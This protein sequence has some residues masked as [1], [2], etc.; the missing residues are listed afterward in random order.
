M[1]TRK[2]PTE[3]ITKSREYDLEHIGYDS[4]FL[5]RVVLVDIYKPKKHFPADD[6]SLLL[7]NDGQD[8]PEMPFLQI[9]S[10]L[11]KSNQV[12]PL[13]VAAMHCNADRRLEY[14]TA[15]VL[16]YMNRGARAKYHRKFVIRELIPFLQSKIAPFSFSNIGFAGFSLGGLS[17]LD[18]AWKNQDIFS[19][20]GV[21][22]GSFWWRKRALNDGYVEETDRIMHSLIEAGQYEGKQQYFFQTGQLDEKMDRNHNGI[23]DSIEDTLDIIKSLK[24]MGVNEAESI[25]YLELEDGRHDVPTWA[26]AWPEFLKWAWPAVQPMD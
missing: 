15:D 7:V 9:I 8:L 2:A 25:K 17:A 26:R 12:S 21:F 22:S 14:G 23:I 6:L 16:D 13:V 20:V 19:K 10:T 1:N 5:D 3:S 24:A 11:V 18:I 4:D